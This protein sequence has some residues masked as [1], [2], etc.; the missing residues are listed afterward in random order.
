MYIWIIF[1]SQIGA[2]LCGALIAFIFSKYNNYK[3]E[4]VERISLLF[5]L[6]SEVNALIALI[7]VRS[8]EFELPN[9]DNLVGYE[10][11]YFP[12]SYNYFTVYENS[13]A[14]IGS[15]ENEK[16]MECVIR[17]YVEVKGLFENTKDLTDLSK[18]FIKHFLEN[19][20][21]ELLHKLI[22]IHYEYSTQIL[23][24]RVPSTVKS[25]GILSSVLKDEIES[26]RK[27]N[28]IFYFI[29]CFLKIC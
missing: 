9:S 12:V 20:N 5:S 15:L 25:L 23:K 21:T 4:L 11:P 14:M 18:L 17:T 27:K 8:H 10:F 24:E 2:A 16:L 22:Q 26:C 1:D 13:A 6:Y 19:P 28:N 29:C 7:E 3:K